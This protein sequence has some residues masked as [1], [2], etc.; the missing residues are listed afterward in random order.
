MSITYT[1]LFAEKVRMMPLE[2]K[3]TLAAKLDL[4]AENP[5]HPSLRTK[6]IQGQVGLFEASVSMSIRITWQYTDDGILLRNIGEEVPH[7]DFKERR[8]D[9]V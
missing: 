4:M 9:L 1:D 6:K 8:A 5:R 3:K 2:A 7:E